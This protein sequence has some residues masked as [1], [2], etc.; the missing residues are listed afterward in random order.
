MLH[1][2]SYHRANGHACLVTLLIMS[3]GFGLIGACIAGAEYER[4]LESCLDLARLAY[5]TEAH[6]REKGAFKTPDA[7]L[8]VFFLQL[9]FCIRSLLQ[10]CNAG[11]QLG[12]LFRSVSSNATSCFSTLPACVSEQQCNLASNRVFA[13]LVQL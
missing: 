8:Q 3:T 7:L 9:K 12:N 13:V 10:S 1:I 2:C 11:M 5:D 6:L 4:Q